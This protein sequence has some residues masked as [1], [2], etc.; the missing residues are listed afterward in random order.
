LIQEVEFQTPMQESKSSQLFEHWRLRNR[1]NNET[2]E[3]VAV[4]STIPVESITDRIYAID[5]VPD[6]WFSRPSPESFD[7][8]V[9]KYQKEEW[10]KSF[11][12]SPK[13]LDRNLMGWDENTFR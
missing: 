1:R 2:G 6:A 5:T 8:V 10:P 4:F 11:L 12:K 7:I 13:Y 9:V 3:Y